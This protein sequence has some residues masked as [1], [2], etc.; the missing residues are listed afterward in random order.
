MLLLA[1][2]LMTANLGDFVLESGKVLKDLT[3][4]YRTYGTRNA[5]GSN[6]I[7]FP[8]W[9]NGKTDGAE[10][11]VIDKNAFV[12]QTKYF[13]ITVDAIGNG[14]S[15]SPSNSTTQKGKA[16]PRITIA[17]MVRSQHLLLTK[18]LNVNRLHAV[19]GISMGGMQAFEWMG[20]YPDFMKKGISIVGTPHMTGADM[21]L[22]MEMATS[23]VGGGGGG[24]K[25]GNGGMQQTILN[26]ILG[27]LGARGGGGGSS[28]PAPDNAF[29][30]FNAMATHNVT[31]LFGNSLEAT[32][33]GIRAETM[34]FVAD[35]DKAVSN[36]IPL[37]FARLKGSRVIRLRSPDGHNAFKTERELISKEALPFLDGVKPNSI[38]N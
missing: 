21:A 37:E 15:T 38:F 1:A 11:Y 7:L 9:F 19:V 31:R 36:D 25:K 17:D 10:T 27:A 35:A 2:A 18:H 5:D 14:V 28:I 23:K 26:G 22:W 12:D 30:Q 3:I 6:V 24:A 13:I 33:K 34:I 16:F 8:T 32:A 20:R 4:G 29:Y